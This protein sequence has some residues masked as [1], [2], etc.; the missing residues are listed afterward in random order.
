M[1]AAGVDLLDLPTALG[2]DVLV[3]R[4]S[5]MTSQPWRRASVAM[6]SNTLP[7]ASRTLTVLPGMRIS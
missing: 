5:S 4:G 2:A 1:T 3:G 6:A 7:S